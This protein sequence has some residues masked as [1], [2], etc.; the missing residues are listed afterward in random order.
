MIWR[1][2]IDAT[3]VALGLEL[4]A[5]NPGVKHLAGTDT[6]AN[7][8]LAGSLGVRAC[9]TSRPEPG[10]QHSAHE[11]GCTKSGHVGVPAIG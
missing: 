7:Q 9:I 1:R 4:G 2:A 8:V 6:V 10:Q 11:T 5:W 3:V